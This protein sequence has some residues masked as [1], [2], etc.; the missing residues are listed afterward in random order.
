MISLGDAGLV[1]AA[2]VAGGV[3]GSGGAITSLV[4][5]PALLAIG[6]P[7]LTANVANIVAVVAI[8]PGSALASGPELRGRGPWL[9]RTLPL[10][11]AGGL[12][13]AVLLRSTPAGVFTR[14]VPLLIA[15]GAV[16]LLAQPRIAARRGRQ[17]VGAGAGAAGGSS[18]PSWWW[19]L[20]MIAVYTGY[21]GAGSGVLALAL[22]LLLV[23]DDLL[24]ANALKNMLL[25][26]ST[27]TAALVLIA[28]APVRWGAV[29]PLAAGVFLGSLLGPR[30]R[31][32]P[33]RPDPATS[34]RGLSASGSPCSCGCTSSAD[35]GAPITAQPPGWAPTS[36]LGRRSSV[37]SR[38]TGTRCSQSGSL[39]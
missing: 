36:S 7:A 5:Y 25:G 20:F 33:S 37:A 9:L 4:T 19:S 15:T 38:T 3:I 35:P 32:P 30:P 23:D 29:A 27:A 11:A 26:A 12:F 22:L 14:I 6:L 24:A 34:G 39:R 21:F 8:W 16:T 10:T 13:G 1:F 18:G 17:G 2:G 28:L 31:T